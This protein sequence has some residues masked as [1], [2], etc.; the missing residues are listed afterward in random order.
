MINAVNVRV[1][2]SQEYN[3]IKV[4]VDSS[5]DYTIKKIG[6]GTTQLRNLSDVLAFSPIDGDVLIF[7]ALTGKYVS[8][9]ISSTEIEL[10]NIDAGTF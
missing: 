7:N 3:A 1:D 9:K 6:Y 2:S 5:Q 10:T 4:K 8:K